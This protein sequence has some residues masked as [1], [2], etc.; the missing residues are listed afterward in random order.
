MAH[1]VT[2]AD[3]LHLGECKDA[4]AQL[5]T[6]RRLT[7]ACPLGIASQI[8]D[9]AKEFPSRYWIIDNSGSMATQDGHKLVETSLGM[10]DLTVSRWE[11]LGGSIRWHAEMAA[12]LGARTEFILL[13]D[14]CHRCPTKVVCGDHRHTISEQLDT[15]DAV[16]KT[17]P[18]GRTPLCERIRQVASEI[19]AKAH[20]LRAAGQRCVVTIA[21]DGA[22]T[23]GDV[24]QAMRPLLSLP[25]IV[26]IKLCTDDERVVD[27]WN[28]ID[29]DLELDMD[30]LDD[31]SSEAAE[32]C[33]HN[34]WLAYGLP[35]QRLREWGCSNKVFDLLDEK[36][37]SI[38]EMKDLVGLVLGR[39]A[40]ADL[41]HPQI[42]WDAFEREVSS[43]LGEAVMT[44]NPLKKRET[45]WV[46]LKILK[47]TYNPSA[48]M[49]G[50]CVI[51]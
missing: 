38:G 22:A 14:P 15:I 40:D 30:V 51:C 16:L 48:S 43:A 29:Q 37:L 32:V 33:G 19:S 34:P 11:E 3:N 28:S 26:V 2:T 4:M 7:P 20:E 36:P 49:S 50:S 41:P 27:Y 13:N 1:G 9:S 24:Q 18:T 35:L 39:S 12:H 31:L 23:D 25:V 45:P 21:S 46:D 42:D 10:K 5:N 47:R 44:Y 8:R 17:S 6:I